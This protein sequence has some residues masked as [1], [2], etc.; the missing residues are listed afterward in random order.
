MGSRGIRAHDESQSLSMADIV[1]RTIMFITEKNAIGDTIGANRL[2]DDLE[3]NLAPFHDKQY[4]E[5]MQ[6]IANMKRKK[7]NNSSA[8]AAIAAA[9]SATVYNLKHRALV[10]LADR[11]G[12]FGHMSSPRAT[13]MDD[14]SGGQRYE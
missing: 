9:H 13:E 6:A 5:D 1:Y 3:N 8:R 11:L 12:W 10:K 2:V 14:V 4:D 7:A